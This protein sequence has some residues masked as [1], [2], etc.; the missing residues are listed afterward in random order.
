MTMTCSPAEAASTAAP[1]RT[2]ATTSPSPS[3]DVW[4]VNS[5]LPAFSAM[6]NQISS[7]AF[8]PDPFHA[9]RAAALCWAMEIGRAHVLTPVTNAHL[10]CRLLLEKKITLE[11]T[12]DLA[13]NVDT[14]SATTLPPQQLV[15]TSPALTTTTQ[16]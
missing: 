8:S 11:P 3:A 5:V 14:H 2:S 1:S 4:P 15:P 9:A 6:S 10:V 13:Q 16:F 12:A 7:D